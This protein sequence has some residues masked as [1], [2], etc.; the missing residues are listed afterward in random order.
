MFRAVTVQTF[1]SP[2]FRCSL[3]FVQFSLHPVLVLTELFYQIYIVLTETTVKES[4]VPLCLSAVFLST[5]T[6]Q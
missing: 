5:S 3:A 4:C 6:V 2:G 1:P